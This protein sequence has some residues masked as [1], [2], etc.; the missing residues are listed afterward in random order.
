[1]CLHHAPISGTM[2]TQ[3]LAGLGSGLEGYLRNV[4][5]VA[6][7]L[8]LGGLEVQEVA[9]RQVGQQP[10]KGPQVPVCLRL[11]VLP[12]PLAGGHTHLALLVAAVALEQ[13]QHPVTQNA[14]VTCLQRRKDL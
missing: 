5:G 11:G 4:D 6:V 10:Q 14:G 3:G 12:Q 2:H 9:L 1:M 7:G 13:L 8:G